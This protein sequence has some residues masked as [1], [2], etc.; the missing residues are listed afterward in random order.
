MQNDFNKCLKEQNNHDFMIFEVL[1]VIH[2]NNKALRKDREQVY[3]DQYYDN[4]QQCYNLQKFANI[5]TY[6]KNVSEEAR[7]KMSEAS[8]TYWELDGAKEK[9]AEQTREMWKDEKT[10]KRVSAS[11]SKSLLK[12]K[13]QLSENAK[14]T[15]KIHRETIMSGL[16]S[17]FEN[18]T[19]EEREQIGEKNTL[20]YI[21]VAKEKQKKIKITKIISCFEGKRSPR[22]KLIENANLLSPE[23]ILYR[24]IYNMNDFTRTNGF[25]PHE[26]WELVKLVR[27]ESFCYK[28]WTRYL[29]YDRNIFDKEKRSKK[30]KELRKNVGLEGCLVKV[31]GNLISP[32]GTIYNNVSGLHRF[33]KAHGLYKSHLQNLFNGKA[34]SHKGWRSC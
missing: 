23:G 26:S 24:N 30:Q 4:K 28:G 11:I 14:R 20:R 25:D 2:G 34:K 16:K 10:R 9:R 17:R 6:P 8:R 15:W 29:K 1:E 31:Y 12:N 3:I 13:E 33:A 21:K 18:L 7:R 5:V 19:K 22:S 27:L 32:D